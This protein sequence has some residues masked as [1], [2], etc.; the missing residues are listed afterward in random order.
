MNEE[1]GKVGLAPLSY[2]TD[3][4]PAAD[5]R[6]KEIAELFSHTRPDGTECSTALDTIHVDY[7]A[8]GENI[9]SGFMGAAAV[10]SGWMNSSGH[11]ENI[12]KEEFN[13]VVVG[14]FEKDGIPYWV[15]LF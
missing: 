8:A 4:Q 10:M 7:Y 2:Y 14:Y 5:M 11:K 1:R 13:A 6:A 12:L 9:A 15:Q 3:A